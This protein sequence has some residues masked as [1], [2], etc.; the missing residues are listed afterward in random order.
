MKDRKE[1]EDFIAHSGYE[2]DIVQ[3]TILEVLLDV[4]EM[5]K[6]KYMESVTL[7]GFEATLQEIHQEENPTI[8]DD[9]LPE[10]F[11]DWIGNRSF[12]DI[13]E[14]A[15][16]YCYSMGQRQNWKVL[17]EDYWRENFGPLPTEYGDL[18]K[19]KL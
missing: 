8:L 15:Q 4:R 3:L 14:F 16:T 11:S 6:D 7:D 9:N 19:P 12:Q 2:P 18:V 5:L 10:A 13:Q 1:I 17:A